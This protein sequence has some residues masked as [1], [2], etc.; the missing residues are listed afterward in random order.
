M[1]WCWSQTISKLAAAIPLGI[2]WAGGQANLQCIVN[3][4][5]GLLLGA[6]SAAELSAALFTVLEALEVVVQNGKLE[7]ESIGGVFPKATFTGTA[8][9][10]D[11]NP[12][13]AP[14]KQT[15][16]DTNV[17]EVPAGTYTVSWPNPS[18]T[19]SEI[20]VQVV[21][22]QKTVVR[23]SSFRFPQGNGEVYPLKD[24][25]G[26]VIWNAPIKFGDAV[27][28]LPG[29]TSSNCRGDWRR[30][31]HFARCANAARFRHADR[32]FGYPLAARD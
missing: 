17:I 15:L 25:A 29:P 27:W 14:F 10:K 3:K 21:S 2:A 16:T 8:T 24:Q 31:D 7:I 19:T 9:S 30:G 32:C 23:G 1:P 20:T 6:G 4:S 5:G 22:N 28:V 13:G 12:S 26:V 18:G 11:S